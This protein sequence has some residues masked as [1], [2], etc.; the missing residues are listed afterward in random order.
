MENCWM[1]P[2]GDVYYCKMHSI[3]ANDVIELLGLDEEY[4]AYREMTDNDDL[5]AFLEYK[6]FAKYCEN[7]HY[8]GWHIS[9][10]KRFTKAQKDE[11]FKLTGDVIE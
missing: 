2:R 8:Q 1:S 6:G 9:P 11:I 3:G 4:F 5:E 7:K 10:E